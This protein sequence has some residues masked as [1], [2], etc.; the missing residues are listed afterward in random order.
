MHAHDLEPVRYQGKENTQMQEAEIF[1]DIIGAF[2][3]P[4][5]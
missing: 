2:Q 4:F 1:S 3:S 5:L